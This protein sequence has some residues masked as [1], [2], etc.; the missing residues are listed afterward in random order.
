MVPS[1]P[2][3]VDDI[4]MFPATGSVFRAFAWN[5]SQLFV[6]GGYAGF[7]GTST[8][9]LFNP[10]TNS[11]T[12]TALTGAPAWADLS[13]AVWTGT[14]FIVWGGSGASASYTP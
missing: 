9:G 6:W 13:Q 10:S 1:S 4:N 7:G 12:A 3:D 14:K 5:G 11:W 8:G 2:V